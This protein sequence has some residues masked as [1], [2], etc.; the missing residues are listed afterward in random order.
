MKEYIKNLSFLKINFIPNLILQEALN[1]DQHQFKIFR[2]KNKI[3]LKIIKVIEY[4]EYKVKL[5]CKWKNL[6]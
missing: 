3:K 5:I 4:K 1:L 6:D 2:I